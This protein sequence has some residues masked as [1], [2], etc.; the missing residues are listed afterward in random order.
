M[1]PCPVTGG[2]GEKKKYI[3]ERSEKQNMERQQPSD[4]Y[5]SF[6]ETRIHCLILWST[7]WITETETA[8]NSLRL[9]NHNCRLLPNASR[10]GG[11]AGWQTGWKQSGHCENIIWKAVTV[12]G[13]WLEYN[14]QDFLSSTFTELQEGSGHLVLSFFPGFSRLASWLLLRMM[15]NACCAI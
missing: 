8:A 1:Q 14:M 2:G 13:T 3:H 12:P 4:I 7:C 10:I 15:G 11:Q 5:R 9:S 6:A